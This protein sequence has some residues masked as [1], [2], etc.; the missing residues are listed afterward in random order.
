MSKRAQGDR[1]G[2]SVLIGQAVGRRGSLLG[3]A[4]SYVFACSIM[5]SSE[6]G[7]NDEFGCPRSVRARTPSNG[8]PHTR[9]AQES[10]HFGS[11]VAGRVLRQLENCIFHAI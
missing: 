3:G 6:F 7:G 9:F 1:I 2:N 11:I 8:D 4:N 10:R 5:N